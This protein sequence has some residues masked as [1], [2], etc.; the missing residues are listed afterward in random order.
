MRYNNN[1][2]NVIN[3]APASALIVDNPPVLRDMIFAAHPFP[4]RSLDFM[5]LTFAMFAALS[6]V[7][8]SA[9]FAAPPKDGKKPVAAKPVVKTTAKVTD[10][11][12]CPVTGEKIADHKTEAGKPEVVGNYR[13]HFCCGGCDTSFAKLS[14]KDKTEKAAAAAKKDTDA[15]AKKG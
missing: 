5:K 4:I 7:S 9:V 1:G 13:V 6:V 2:A 10:V 3:R 8:A 12:T 15:T 11:W 14:A